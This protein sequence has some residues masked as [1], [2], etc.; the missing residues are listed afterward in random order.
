MDRKGYTSL[1][2]SIDF[3]KTD[4][5]LTL[6]VVHKYISRFALRF[7]DG[8]D[9]QKA[10]FTSDY[11]IARGH[12]TAKFKHNIKGGKHIKVSIFNPFTNIPR[13]YKEYILTDI[14]RYFPSSSLLTNYLNSLNL[15][16]K[17]KLVDRRIEIIYDDHENIHIL[18]FSFPLQYIL[19]FQNKFI[20]DKRYIADFIPQL[21]KAYGDIYIYSDIVNTSYVGG[22]LTPLLKSL[23]INKSLKFGQELVYEIPFPLYTDVAKSSVNQIIVNIRNHDGEYIPFAESAVTTLTLHFKQ[24]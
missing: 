19:G 12:I 18:D 6:G 11:L 1:K 2:D 10:G 21:D 16:I 24:L 8:N 15:P 17:F 9:A 23:N 3:D 20:P 4:D 7:K 13:N 5:I 14:D 22:T